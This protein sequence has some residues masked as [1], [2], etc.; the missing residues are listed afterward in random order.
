M[1]T[2]I[3]GKRFLIQKFHTTFIQEAELKEMI[4]AYHSASGQTNAINDR[5]TVLGPQK[6]AEK[7]SCRRNS[8]RKSLEKKSTGKK[9][10][11]EKEIPKKETRKI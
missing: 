3:C 6:S 5:R 7:E 4:D 1:F 10:E 8:N 9:R 11:D 2:N